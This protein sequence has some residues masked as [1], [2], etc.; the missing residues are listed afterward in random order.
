MLAAIFK[1]HLT[2]RLL[3]QLSAGEIVPESFDN[4]N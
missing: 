2:A 1:C 3:L 4:I